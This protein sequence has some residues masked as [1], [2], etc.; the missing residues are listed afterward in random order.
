MANYGFK[1]GKNKQAVYSKTE[2]DAAIQAAAEDLQDQI[3]GLLT[4]KQN[5]HTTRQ[6]VLP[7]AS[8]SNNTLTVTVAG[9]KADNLVQITPAPVSVYAWGNAGVRCTAQGT[10]S[11]TFECLAVPSGDLTANIVIWD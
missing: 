3:S 7:L 5:T 10:N 1:D 2:T 9:V 4:A 6:A 11:L 8:W